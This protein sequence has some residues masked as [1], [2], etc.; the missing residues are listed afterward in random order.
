MPRPNH[1][2]GSRGYGS[3]SLLMSAFLRIEGHCGKL[4]AVAVSI[5]LSVPAHLAGQTFQGSV[6]DEMTNA[7]VATTSVRLIS[8][9]GNLRGGSIADASGFYSIDVPGPGIYRLQGEML[10]YENFLTPPLE[11]RNPEGVHPVDLLLRRSPLLMESL[12]VS[13]EFPVR[14]SID[15]SPNAFRYKPIQFEDI[16]YH[17]GWGRDVS[18]VLRRPIPG[19]LIAF[20]TTEGPCLSLRSLNCLPVTPNGMHPS[21]DFPTDGLDGPY[22][23]YYENGQLKTRGTIRDGEV[24]GR[25]EDYYE[26]GQLKTKGT[27]KDGEPDGPYEHY[28]ENGRL[29]TK[30]TMKDGEVEGPWEEY[31]ENGQLMTKR[32]YRA[33]GYDG[34]SERYD[35]NGQ[36]QLKSTYKDGVVDGWTEEY[37]ENGRLKTKATYKDGYPDGPWE[38]YYENGRLKTRGTYKD[39][40]RTGGWEE[41]YENGQLRMKRTYMW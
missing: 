41:Y 3:T 29:M 21:P 16:P 10:G 18:D 25:W 14:S 15:L 2:G 39:G 5:A 26:D 27:M 13:V 32:T 23:E 35:E 37:Y 17:I 12:V 20:N 34:P 19:R 6:L 9:D 33:G 38:E 31:D 11:V 22:E 24:E 4:T 28:D 40:D 7:P 30:G 1:R 36:L 8:E